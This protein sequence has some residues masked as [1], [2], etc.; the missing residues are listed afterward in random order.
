MKKRLVAIVVLIALCTLCACGAKT[1]FELKKVDDGYICYG[2]KNDADATGY[3]HIP[4]EINGKPVYQIGGS[5]FDESD[6]TEV[7]IDAGIKR[8]NDYAFGCSPELE[9]VELPRSLKYI[10]MSAFISCT[11]LEQIHIPM[12]VTQLEMWA[13][14]GCSS[15]ETVVIEG[16]IE[17]LDTEVFQGCE[18]LKVIYLPDTVTNIYQGA[19]ENCDALE[20]IHFA[21]TTEEFLAIDFGRYW[22]TAQ[23]VLVCCA[24]GNLLLEDSN[25]WS[26]TD[27]QPQYPADPMDALAG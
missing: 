24:D 2:F 9:S 7:T 26:H 16:E 17:T 12:N 14:N 8:I 27:L 5:A 13:F 18:S 3:L 1:P 19:L 4:S 10:G 6:I 25:S 22:L 11:S 21:G 15:L 23:N 20:E